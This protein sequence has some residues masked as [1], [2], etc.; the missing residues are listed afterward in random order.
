VG[1]F[2]PAIV[3]PQWVLA[4]EPAQLT[5]ML[6]HEQEHRQAGDGRLLTLAQL[7]LIAMPWNVAL[8]WQIFRLRVAVELDCDARVLRKPTARTAICCSSSRVRGAGSLLGVTAFAE[9]AAQLERRIRLLARSRMRTSAAARAVATCIGVAALTG[10]W[11]APRPAV[12]GRAPVSPTPPTRTVA[13]PLTVLQINDPIVPRAAEK[14]PTT[15]AGKRASGS[16]APTPRITAPPCGGAAGRENA[17]LSDSVFDRLFE[18]ITLS[19]SQANKACALLAR[20]EQQQAAED[21][22]TSVTLLENQARA[23]SLR[24]QRD[25]ALRALLT[26]DADRATLDARLAQPALGGRGRGGGTGADPAAGGR[27]GGGGGGDSTRLFGR[28]GGAGGRGGGGGR[29]APAA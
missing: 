16:A 12:P 10:A 26:N 14:V 20:L 2:N 11:V 8:W 1:A 23:L 28:T 5:L 13:A 7:A 17:R 19:A 6:R 3:V 15:P 27:R 29:G 22:M 24:A 18:G 9:R 25:S 4:L 21:A